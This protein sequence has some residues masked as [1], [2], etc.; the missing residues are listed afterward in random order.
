[1]GYNSID[2]VLSVPLKILEECAKIS[3]KLFEALGL[4]TPE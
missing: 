3:K 4:P 1:V 2:T